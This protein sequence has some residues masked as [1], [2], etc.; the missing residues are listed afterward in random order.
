[1]KTLLAKSKPEFTPLKD[2]LEHVAQAA[3][4][5]ARY[6]NMDRAVAHHGAL[7]HDIGKAHPVFQN[8]LLET[9]PNPKVFRHEIASL[10]FLSAFPEIEYAPLIEMVVGHHKSI[11]RDVGEKG[12]LDLEKG[13]HFREFH[14][15]DWD[16]WSPQAFD[17]LN[18]LG[19]ECT[20][21]SKEQAF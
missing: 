12:L 14:L 20:A 2:H 11:K 15:G 8:R 19:V 4:V 16:E 18:E 6:L 17:L 1:M 13:S 3:V 10:F 5:F 7:L 21:F 9:N